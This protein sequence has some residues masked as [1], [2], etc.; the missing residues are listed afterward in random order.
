M[1]R[2]IFAGKKRFSEVP[3]LADASKELVEAV[4]AAISLAEMSGGP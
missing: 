4:P 3:D 2:R 1:R